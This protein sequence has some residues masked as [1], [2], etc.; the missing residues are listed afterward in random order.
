MNKAADIWDTPHQYLTTR[1]PDTPVHFFAPSVLKEQANKFL[2][3]FQGLATYAVKANPD[4]A[5]LSNLVSCGISGFDVASP[6]EIELVQSISSK[7]AIHYNNPVRSR[8]EIMFALKRGVRSFSVDSMPELN[9]IADLASSKKLEISVRFKLPVTGAEYDFGEKFGAE[10]YQAE[11]LLKAVNR[12]GHKASMTFHP[13]T[14]CQDPTAWVKYIKAAAIISNN[15]GVHPQRLNV[16]GGFPSRMEGESPKLDIFFN[17]I[18]AAVKSAFGEDAPDLI[19]EPGR[20]IVAQSFAHAIRVKS[21]RYDGAIYVNDGIYGGLSEFPSMQKKRQV[22]VISPNGT[23]KNGQNYT[24][25]VFGPTCDSLDTIPRN[26]SLP[27]DIAEEDYIIF[28]N[29]GAYVHGVTTE[30]N[31]YGYLDTATVISLE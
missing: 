4:P 23:V 5:V 22:S 8:S 10:P 13:G 3:G 7:A 29:M 15:A 17:S 2:N 28:Q 25:I 9:K 19:C 1:L 31:G 11:E 30:F 16:G 12:H 27:S 14:Q 24:P 20:A 6:R 26:I 21:V 18:S